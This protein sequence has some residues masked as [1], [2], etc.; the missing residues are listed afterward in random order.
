MPAK[1]EPRSGLNY[2]WNYGEFSW[3]TGTDANWLKIGRFAFHLSAKSRALIN[4]P[5][6]PAIGATYIVP[7]GATGAWLGLDGRVAV[8]AGTVWETAAPAVGWVAYIEDEGVLSAF[9]ASG[10]SAGLSI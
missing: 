8:W 3:N 9:K 5:A 1:Q 4:P 7:T 6:S 10:W 2:G